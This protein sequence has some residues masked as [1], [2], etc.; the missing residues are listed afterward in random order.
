MTDRNLLTILAFLLSSALFAQ[1]KDAGLW[2]SVSFKGEFS[3][4]LQWS[5]APEVRLRDNMTNVSSVFTDVGLDL[6]LAKKFSLA[7]TYRFGQRNEIDFFETRQRLQLGLGYKISYND[8]TIN[9]ATRY[10]GRIEGGQDDG[11]AD[12]ATTW[13]NKISVKFEGFKKWELGTSYEIFHAY[14]DGVALKWNDW[15]WTASA[16][17]KINK[18]NFYS[19]GYL[20]QRDLVSSEPSMDF[21]VLL[22][23]KH[24]FKKKKKDEEA[25]ITP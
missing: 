2:T 20:I 22:S 18:R 17:R 6:D 13:R 12:F 1:Q 8:W 25:I 7:L 23:Y 19:V 16:E 11:D 21:V 10:Q 5:V 14:D 3:K 4:K 9:L 15:R 24:V